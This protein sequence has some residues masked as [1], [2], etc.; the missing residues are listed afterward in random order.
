[1]KL[2]YTEYPSEKL[3]DLSL[4]DYAISNQNRGTLCYKLEFG[5]Y[6]ECEPGIV[7][8]FI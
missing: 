3:K 5:K 4:E 7:G 8:G 2:F 1:M 6:R